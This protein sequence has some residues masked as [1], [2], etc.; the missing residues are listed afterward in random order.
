MKEE[1]LREIKYN[2]FCEVFKI[3]KDEF[4]S[5]T[6]TKNIDWQV[7]LASNNNPL[8]TEYLL[9]GATQYYMYSAYRSKDGNLENED[10]YYGIEIKD[11]PNYERKSVFADYNG[12]Q[13]FVGRYEFQKSQDYKTDHPFD[14]MKIGFSYELHRW[15]V[16]NQPYLKSIDPFDLKHEKLTTVVISNPKY[17]LHHSETGLE[18]FIDK[19]IKDELVDLY[20]TYEDQM[21]L[22]LKD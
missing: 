1:I 18:F 7:F 4:K 11:L 5:C 6:A 2:T 8:S 19:N 15:I 20:I 10:A 9:T 3:D 21:E 22:I 12:K 17:P 14:H 13:I 16:L